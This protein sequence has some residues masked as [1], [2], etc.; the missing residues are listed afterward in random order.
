VATVVLVSAVVHIS[1]AGATVGVW[2]WKR[3]H[4]PV[5]SRLVLVSLVS[6]ESTG[7]PVSEDR[8]GGEPEVPPALAQQIAELTADNATLAARLADQERR[9]AQIEAEY[10]QSLAALDT[11]TSELGREL[12]TVVAARDALSRQLAAT[13]ERA[14]ALEQELA[15]RQAVEAAAR[16]EVE[17]T[18][19]RLVSLLQAELAARDVALERANARLTV[20]IVD[21]VLFPSGQAALTTDGVRVIDKVG[22]ALAALPD[23]RVLVVGHTDDVPIGA[24][25]RA[26]FPSNWELSTARAT[27]VVKRL[28]DHGHIQASRLDATGRADT[29]PVSPNTT[30]HDRRLN[31]R[32]EIILLA[33]QPSPDPGPS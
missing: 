12:G 24:E 20:T 8:S 11:A 27:T 7:T 6:A 18:Y 5:Q 29:D 4:E 25:L 23:R 31:R 2:W 33:P 22:T 14:G 10:R 19:D 13:R 1:A 30:D 21:R 15:R 17:A 32:I 28:I 16:A 3:A 26:R 9:T